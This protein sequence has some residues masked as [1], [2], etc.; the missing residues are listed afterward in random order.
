MI[1]YFKDLPLKQKIGF[2]CLIVAGLGF[3]FSIIAGAMSNKEPAPNPSPTT[4]SVSNTDSPA[5]TASTAPSAT[6]T[7][8][9]NPADMPEIKYGENKIP[10]TEIRSLQDT[11]SSGL[12]EF[13]KWNANESVD[14][15]STRLSQYFLD[16]SELLKSAPD[17][18]PASRYTTGGTQNGMI[19]VGSVD[20]INA[21][22][23]D[24]TTY[25]LTMGTVLRAQYNY[26]KTGAEKSGVV[27]TSD[28]FSVDMTKVN[29]A[30]KIKAISP[31]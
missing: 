9:A 2:I 12:T 3:L 5:P 10:V 26:E 30:W 16:N 13:L 18:Q 6:A 25:R 15:R 14:A 24:E 20:Y 7:A 28:T 8:S 19:S 22:G 27:I 31:V 23:G 11:A 29:G 1:E 4:P 21:V 17:L